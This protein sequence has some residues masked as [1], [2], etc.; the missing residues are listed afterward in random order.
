MLMWGCGEKAGVR[1]RFRVNVLCANCQRTNVHDLTVPDVEDAPEDI[2][3]LV[4]S[5]FLQRQ[6]FT[7]PKCESSIG[8]VAAI[9][10]ADRE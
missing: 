1:A 10:Q 9:R 4:E 6:R 3:S 8:L 2:D 7:C 5:A